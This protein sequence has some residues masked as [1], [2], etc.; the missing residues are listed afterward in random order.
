MLEVQPKDSR[1]YFML[2]QAPEDAGYYVYGTPVQGAGQYAHPSL[3]T[4]LFVV[5]RE[6]QKTDNR[7]FGIGNISLAGGGKFKPHATHK[8]GLQ[9]DVRPLRKD[10]AHV[11][12]TYFQAGYDKGATARLITLF[13]AHPAVIK[14]Y[15]NDLTIPGVCPLADHDNHFHVEMRAGTR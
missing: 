6:W 12:V 3:M 14:M 4:V 8:D 10:G 9:V 15:F 1:G 13:Q 2:P 7:K 5:E 11:P